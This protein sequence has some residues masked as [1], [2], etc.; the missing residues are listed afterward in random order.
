MAQVV[1]VGAGPTGLTLA[2][3]L[4]KR[5][6]S[7]KL[8]EASRTFRRIF[9]GEALMPSG[10]DA[11][12]QMGL[13]NAVEQTPHRVLDAWE[14][15]IEKRSI[16]RVNEPM[17]LQG[18]PCT[19]IS[20]PAFLDAVIHQISGCAN[21]E[22]IQGS[23]VRE[24]LWQEGRVAGIKLADGRA[25]AADLVIGADGRNSIVRQQANLALDQAEQSF[26]ILWFKLPTHPRFQRENVFYSI[27][28]GRDGFGVFQGS[29]GD[30]QVG[31]SVHRDEPEP[32]PVSW[33]EKLASASPDWLAEHFR[34]QA[35]AI[36]RPL[37]LSIVVGRA[38]RWYLPGLLLLGDAVHPMSPIRAQGINMALRDVVVAVN[39]L[40]PVLEKPA[41]EI[42]AVLPR[43]QAEREPEIVEIQR[44]Q[45]AEIAQGEL[46]RNYPILR[47]GV[48]RLAPVIGSG[49]R[50]S[51]LDRQLRLRRGV[52]EVKL[53]V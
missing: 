33:G 36:E 19:L 11:I 22:L 34:Q 5:G 17:E 15:Y 27:L 31:W 32:P 38:P 13:S 26:D 12:A 4:V 1:V 52:A 51:W 8:V 43:I 23:A 3:L 42:D 16:F 50:K 46:M 10:L 35:D 7:V 18:Q 49:V 2:M 30:L 9:R 25:I 29:E 37:L 47:Y 41:H 53:K 20:Q 44:L 21:F 14:F 45:Q 6:I 28:C 39:H 40:V 24:L 48:S